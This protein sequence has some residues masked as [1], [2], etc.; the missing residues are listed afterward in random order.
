MTTSLLAVGFGEPI[1]K[2]SN[3]NHNDVRP[4]HLVVVLVASLKHLHFVDA[5]RSNDSS[6]TGRDYA[7][8]P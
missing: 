8:G 7:E 3:E 1:T 6:Y 4:L 5:W 2:S